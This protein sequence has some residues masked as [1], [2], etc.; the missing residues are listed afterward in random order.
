MVAAAYAL[1]AD[2]AELQRSAAVGAVAL[3]Q[4]NLAGAITKHHQFLAEDLHRERQVLE[5]IRVADRLPEPSHVLAA[6]CVWADMRQL[7]V[8]LR[9]LPMMIS[10]VPRL[11]ERSP[12]DR[13]YKASCPGVVGASLR[14]RNLLVG[15][16]G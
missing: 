9:N 5:L 2:Q 1:R 15:I 11:Q 14:C 13:H 4:A 7:R 8:F 10:A 6:R 12:G 16:L 3:E